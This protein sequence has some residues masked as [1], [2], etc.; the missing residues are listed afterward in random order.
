M[1]AKFHHWRLGFKQSSLRHIM[2]ADRRIV[3]DI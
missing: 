1:D 3:L 2:R